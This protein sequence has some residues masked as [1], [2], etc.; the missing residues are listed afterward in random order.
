MCD[1]SLHAAAS[2]PARTGDKLVISRFPYTF[3]RGFA[4]LLAIKW[5]V[6]G[7]LTW[8][9]QLPTTTQLSSPTVES[10]S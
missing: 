6:L 3:T 10:Y 2:R 4:R 7:E 1:Y 8:K 5:L 9:L